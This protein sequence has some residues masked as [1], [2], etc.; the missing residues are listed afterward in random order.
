[1]V[2]VLRPPGLPLVCSCRSPPAQSRTL[3]HRIPPWHDTEGTVEILAKLGLTS[4]C[5]IMSY[6]GVTLPSH[7]SK[8][9]WF[10][11]GW[12]RHEEISVFSQATSQWLLRAA[13]A[14]QI[15]YTHQIK[16]QKTELC[17]GPL[18]WAVKERVKPPDSLEKPNTHWKCDLIKFQKSAKKKDP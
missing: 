15:F 10:P 13:K 6:R 5:S 4:L 18:R 2:C 17:F 12:Q 11:A 14:A 3:P 1:M 9:V 7:A 16:I 8:A